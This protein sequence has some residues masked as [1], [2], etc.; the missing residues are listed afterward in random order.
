M[1]SFFH[2]S[3]IM[4]QALGKDVNALDILLKN[5][6]KLMAQFEQLR[7]KLHRNDS[8]KASRAPRPLMIVSANNLIEGQFPLP[9]SKYL[10]GLTGTMLP[11]RRILKI[12]DVDLA[13]GKKPYP[14]YKYVS[15]SNRNPLP[16]PEE[17]P[18]WARLGASGCHHH[19]GTTTPH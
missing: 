11:P 3:A 12:H 7:K 5:N 9:K 1:F 15:R 19:T 16:P 14:T 8:A 2:K 10:S 18:L 17:R 13:P 6:P 4:A